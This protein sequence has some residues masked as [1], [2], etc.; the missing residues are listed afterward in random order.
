MAKNGVEL[1]AF[2]RRRTHSWGNFSL[3]Y[4]FGPAA[5]SLERPPLHPRKRLASKERTKLRRI[6]STRSNGGREG[7]A[8]GSFFSHL[9]SHTSLLQLCSC[10]HERKP[11]VSHIRSSCPF[12][13]ASRTKRDGNMEYRIRNM[14]YCTR[15]PERYLVP[16]PNS[17]TSLLRRNETPN[18]TPPSPQPQPRTQ[19]P[20]VKLTVAAPAALENT[21]DVAPH[22]ADPATDALH[23][24]STAGKQGTRPPA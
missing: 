3:P 20:T 17:D 19:S 11:S 23:S 13:D 16:R 7:Q 10:N 6:F 24:V 8:S 14:E 15:K 9:L 12:R 21:I 4:N 1:N 5:V 18:T 2:S 22:A